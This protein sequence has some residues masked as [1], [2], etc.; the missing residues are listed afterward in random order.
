MPHKIER[1]PDTPLEMYRKWFMNLAKRDPVLYEELR[2]RLGVRML[3]LGAVGAGPYGS[4][5]GDIT[6]ESSVDE[7]LQRIAYESIVREG[8]P[9][10]LVQRDEINFQLTEED[11]PAKPIIDKLRGA[12]NVIQ[13]LLPLVGRIDTTN[14][15]ANLPYLGT[16]WLVDRNVVVTNRHVAELMVRA[17]TRDF[18]FKPGRLGEKLQVSIDYRHEYE[19]PAVAIASVKR[20]IW[21]EPDATKADIAFLEVDAANDGRPRGHIDLAPQD[22]ADADSVAVIGYPAR[23]PEFII[24]DQDWMDRIYGG[25]YDIKRVAPGLMGPTSRGWATHDCTT[26]GGCSGSV[27]VEMKKGLAVALH[28]AG[29]YMVENYAV[30]ASII[31]QYLNSRPWERAPFE[32]TIPAPPVAVPAETGAPQDRNGPSGITRTLCF[33]IPVRI[34][35]S[36]GGP[37]PPSTD[38]SP[39]AV[40]STADNTAANAAVAAAGLAQSLADE[41]GVLSVRPGCLLLD[42]KLTATLGLVVAA[43]P[44]A[45]PRI[46]SKLPV[47]FSGFRVS[48]QPASI[49]DQLG[50]G[51]ADVAEAEAVSFIAYNDEDRTGENYSFDWLSGQKMEVIA[52]VGPE[53][54]WSVLQKFLA[55]A[56]QRFVSSMYEFHGNHIAE[57]VRDRLDAGVRMQLVLARQTRNP[58]SG[59]VAAGDFDRKAVFESWHVNHPQ[60][61]ENLYVPVGSAGLVAN[62]YHI[63]VTVRDD[64]HVWLSS[65]NWKRASQPVIP[66]GSLD[67]PRKTSSAGNREWHV[68]VRNK[69]LADRFRAHIAEDFRYCRDGLGAT[70]EAIGPELYVDVPRSI[71]EAVELEAAAD[72]V[73]E[74]LI[75]RKRE[76][77]VKPLLTPDLRGKVYT[78]AVLHLIESAKHQLLVQ[79]QYI[80]F[81]GVKSGNLKTLVDALCRKSKALDDCRVILRSG[82][83]GFLDDMRALQLTGLDVNRCVKRLANTHTKGIIVDGEQVLVGS[84]NWSSDGVSLN[85]DASLIFD[86]KEIARYFLEVFDADWNRAPDLNFDS[87]DPEAA[88]RLAVGHEPPPGFVRMT[89]ADYRDR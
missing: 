68:I 54:S 13:P 55:G 32:I 37:E 27:V 73:F 44:V 80:S 14:Y 82:G 6:P 9:A 84:H 56:K 30:P 33:N 38:L 4:P 71:L 43:H 50:L 75:I 72:R 8:R 52:H 66:P 10:L 28:F 22:A 58:S 5:Y 51:I 31:R 60:T 83:D 47:E 46:K 64:D 17:G 57:A 40:R 42:G 89:L 45:L 78:D 36:I 86:D 1:T 63:K 11:R 29:L 69:T 53:R 48:L 12:T 81:S 2:Q 49:Q 67:D 26:L 35:V 41:D 65:G 21:I 25:T 7:S 23:A 88:P 19:V 77:R 87:L 61:F 79:N 59:A 85:R 16:G 3:E 15:P 39:A 18:V 62:S 74:P 34:D 70:Q 76:I 20:V 24:P